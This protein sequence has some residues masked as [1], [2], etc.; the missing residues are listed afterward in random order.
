MST[1]QAGVEDPERVICTPSIL[2][3]L[4]GE[5]RGTSIGE[6]ILYPSVKGSSVLV[7]DDGV[8]KTA[9]PLFQSQ[10][11]SIQKLFVRFIA[12]PVV[13]NNLSHF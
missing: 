5:L 9:L 3:D 2:Y 11:I 6:S 7:E 10:L 4:Y 8:D 13:N 12:P 1:K